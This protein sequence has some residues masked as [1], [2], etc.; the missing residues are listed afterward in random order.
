MV[1]DRLPFHQEDHVL[2]DVGGEVGHTF[3]VPAHQEELHPRADHM[4]VLH[5]MGQQDAE[6][7]PVQPVDL[8]VPA[9]DIAGGGRVAPH[10][11]LER[12][13]EHLPRQA[14]HLDQFRLRSDGPGLGQAFRRLRDVDGVIAHPLEVVGDLERRGEHPEVARHRLLEAEELDALLL[15]LD[16]ERVDRTVAGD[17]PMGLGGVPL[18]QGLHRQRK[19]RLRL[20]RH[21]E[22][23]D[24]DVAQLVV[25]MAVLVLGHPNL[26]V[27]YASVRSSVGVVNNRRVSPYST[28]RPESK[29]AVKSEARA[30]C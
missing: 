22:E 30:A 2:P 19:G 20:A 5:H 7:R 4:G 18:E 9:A 8:I 11:G 26:P 24:L 29:N 12:I 6:H 14:R 1:L 28:S 25:E 16:L 23:P 15:D 17:D 10:E 21:R 27:M 13:G 3:Q